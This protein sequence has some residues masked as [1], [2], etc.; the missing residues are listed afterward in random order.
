VTLVDAKYIS[1]VNIW[2]LTLCSIRGIDW[3]NH[4]SAYY[5]QERERLHQWSNQVRYLERDCD[6]QIHVYLHSTQ[7]NC[8]C[9]SHYYQ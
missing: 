6:A 8:H 5:G 7:T 9:R 3:W 1:E 2:Q 4:F